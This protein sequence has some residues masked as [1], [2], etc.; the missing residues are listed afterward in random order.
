MMTED[1]KNAKVIAMVRKCMEQ[2]RMKLLNRQPFI[3]AV[4]MHLELEPTTDSVFCPT[5][6]TDGLTVY[7]N[8]KF[9]AGL[10]FEERIF[11]LAHETWHCVML[12]FVRIQSREP[13]RFN[14]ATDLEIHFILS[15]EKMKEPFVL[16]HDPAWDGLSAEEIY[17]KLRQPNHGDPARGKSSKGISGIDGGGFDRHVYHSGADNE[18]AVEKLRRIVIRSAQLAERRQGALPAHI[19]GVIEKLRKPELNWREVLKQFVTSCYGGSRHWLPPAR[20]YVG[21]GLY[22]PSRREDN[23]ENIVVAMDISGSMQWNLP[24]IFGELTS[25][26]KSFGRYNLDVLQCDTEITNVQHFDENHPFADNDIHFI[27]KTGGNCFM[28][29]FDYIRTQK[30]HPA[31]LIYLTDGYLSTDDANPPP[32]YGP[33]YPVLWVLTKDGKRPVKWGKCIRL[34]QEFVDSD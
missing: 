4:L 29:V 20:R 10:D 18:E 11:V 3:G 23:L 9:Y 32:Q 1:E 17:E 30:M 27:R 26:L 15:K 34:K 14:I 6:K 33:P 28:P 16:P 13:K 5:A 31:L 12:H 8:C 7:M 22:L 19:V 21:M 24:M 25:L 2:D